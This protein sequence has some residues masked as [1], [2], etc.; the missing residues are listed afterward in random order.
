[1]VERLS[2]VKRQDPSKVGGSIP[3]IST[4]TPPGNRK[5]CRGKVPLRIRR[6]NSPDNLAIGA[7]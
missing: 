7:P 3:L 2:G 6:G 4:L 1:M 5:G